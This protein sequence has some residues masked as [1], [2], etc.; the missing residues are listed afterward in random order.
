[1]G[2]F[3]NLFL[4]PMA[5]SIERVLGQMRRGTQIRVQAQPPVSPSVSL[6]LVGQAKTE[7]AR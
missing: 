3:P 1:M 7:V 5:P 4:K 6:A 2:V